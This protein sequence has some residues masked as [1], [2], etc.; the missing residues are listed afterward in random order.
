MKNKELHWINTMFLFVS[1]CI[2]D[3]PHG[4]NKSQSCLICR[5][6]WRKVIGGIW[7][8]RM[9]SI[10]CARMFILNLCERYPVWW[11]ESKLKGPFIN[12]VKVPTTLLVSGSLS[13]LQIIFAI[14][15]PHFY[16]HI[17]EEENIYQ[18][19][20]NLL[21]NLQNGNCLDFLICIKVV[22]D[23]YWIHW[24]LFL[25]NKCSSS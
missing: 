1:K 9:I 4:L 5:A 24:P 15:S 10:I 23:Q 3:V 13:G 25:L 22:I 14:N 12:D 21:I 20:T 19:C 17:C 8:Q 7:G 2:S 16:Q 18:S 11:R 6:D